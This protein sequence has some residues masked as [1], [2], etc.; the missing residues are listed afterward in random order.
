MH[1]QHTNLPPRLRLNEH[2][3]AGLRVAYQ[4]L[5]KPLILPLCIEVDHHRHKQGLA[6]L[7]VVGT[8]RSGE[9]EGEGVGVSRMWVRGGGRWGVAA[10][11]ADCCDAWFDLVNLVNTSSDHMPQTQQQH[12]RSPVVVIAGMLS[13]GRCWW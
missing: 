8:A 3:S 7:P 10:A 6:R 1:Q 5:S 12:R 4:R 9:V 2:S 11:A 13:E